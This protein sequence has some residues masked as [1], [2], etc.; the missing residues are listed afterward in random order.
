MLPQ[1][2]I[3]FNFMLWEPDPLHL[4]IGTLYVAKLVLGWSI[5]NRLV[6]RL[7]QVTVV[8]HAALQHCSSHICR[9][10]AGVVGVGGGGG[11]GDLMPLFTAVLGKLKYLSLVQQL[12]KPRAFLPPAF[13]SISQLSVCRRDRR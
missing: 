13:D 3:P 1:T 7:L 11:G 4:C 8:R 6:S 10:T 5:S 9:S 12:E 2:L